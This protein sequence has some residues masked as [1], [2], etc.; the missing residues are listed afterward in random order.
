MKGAQLANR[1]L[2]VASVIVTGAI[3]G[4]FVWL[5]LVRHEPGHH[6]HLGPAARAFRPVLPL[7]RLPGGRPGH[8][9]FAKKFG[10]YPEDLNQVM[11]KVKR[12]GRYDYDKL[13]VMSVSALLPLFFGGSV[14]PSGPHRGGRGLCTWWAIA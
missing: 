7:G 11:A 4:A 9:L 14:G 6:V 12:D 5:L 2:F 1:T 13:G 8:R 3:A 10:S